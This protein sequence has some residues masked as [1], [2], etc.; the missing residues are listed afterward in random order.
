MPYRKRATNR[1]KGQRKL[2]MNAPTVKFT[3]TKHYEL[4]SGNAH[5]SVFMKGIKM[6]TPFQPLFDVTNNSNETLGD[7]EANDTLNEPIGLNSALYAHYNNLVVKGCKVVATV[8]QA[9]DAEEQPGDTLTTGQIT[10]ARTAN[11]IDTVSDIPT[12]KDIKTW[13]GHKTRNFQLAP[14]GAISP[15][16]K[17]CYVS[18]G[19]SARKQFNANA[20]TKEEL[21]V[22]NES[23]S[24][25]Q[26][27]DNTYMYVIVQPRKDYAADGNNYL[28]PMNIT[29]RIS[30]ICQFQDPDRL[31]SVPLPLSTGSRASGNKKKLYKKNKY[32]YS[33]SPAGY[34]GLG[35]LG[36]MLAMRRPRQRLI[37][38]VPQY[39]W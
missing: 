32:Q 16:T 21:T 31:Q 9:P 19:Y 25:N 1:L 7:W 29:V 12:A 23:G 5:S 24:A 17:N 15:L 35:V 2:K 34:A 26:A 36:S 6:S 11:E 27:Q 37:G 38:H 20:N 33:Y 8:N 13:F 4:K 22:V 3:L 10:L 28:S 14:R 39:V 18:N 30:Y